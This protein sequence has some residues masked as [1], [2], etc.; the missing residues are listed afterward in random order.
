MEKPVPEQNNPTTDKGLQNQPRQSL[1]EYLTCLIA[2]H[3]RVPP[4]RVT[5]EYI[6]NERAKRVYPTA[7]YDN[8]TRYGGYSTTGLTFRT[9]KERQAIATEVD[10]RLAEFE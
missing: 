2:I 3:D 1:D 9:M 8:G 5:V 7:R 6:R 10:R 4:A